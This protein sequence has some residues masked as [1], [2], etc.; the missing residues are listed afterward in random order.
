MIRLNT[1]V[2]SARNARICRSN[3][4]LVCSSKVAGISMG[5]SGRSTDCAPSFSVLWIRFSMSRT[6]SRY[7][8][9]FLRSCG[10]SDPA[11][12]LAS[13][14][15][16]S[17]MLAVS[18]AWAERCALVPPS[19][20]NRSNTSAWMIF[21]DVGR[22]LVAPGNGVDVKAVARI[23]GALGR[24]I[25]G[26]FERGN[27]RIFSDD[28]RGNLIGG[29]CQADFDA[30]TGAVVSMDTG[31]PGSGRARVIAAAI[32]FGIGFQLRQAGEHI[33]AVAHR[34]KRLQNRR[35]LVVCAGLRGDPLLQNDAVGNVDESQARR[36]LGRL[37]GKR[38]DHGIQQRQRQRGAQPS[39]EGSAVK[40]LLGNKRHRLFSC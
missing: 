10:P 26:H 23:A 12:R 18:C 2:T 11:R 1:R 9:S 33:H 22:G 4:S 40:R 32:A 29:S 36:R 30:R 25:H 20:N 31:K 24:R 15:T 6:E 7:S 27:G 37:G 38:R 35:Q 13:S 14:V 17:R 5:R 16:E 28:A 3:I 34:L 19:P 8:L 39:Q 21:G